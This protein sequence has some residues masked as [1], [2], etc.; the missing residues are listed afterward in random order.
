MSKTVEE[1]KKQEA[2]Q[3]EMK[4]DIPLPGA[5]GYAEDV[6]YYGDWMLSE[7]KKKI[8]FLYPQITSPETGKVIEV[9]SWIWART[10]KCPN[11]SCGCEIPLS[12]S[13]DLAKKK[14]SEAWVE[15][16]VDGDAVHFRIHREPNTSE[17]G[18]P[19]VAQTAVFTCPVCG[20]IT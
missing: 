20:E 10:V 11:P 12:S 9:S 19:K 6:Q 3:E 2:P 16:Y 18:K 7:A 17:K 4:L 15:P 5:E 1:P 14:G 8:G 13:Y